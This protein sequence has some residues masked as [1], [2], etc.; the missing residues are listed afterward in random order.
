M[1]KWIGVVSSRGLWKSEH[2]FL[3]FPINMSDRFSGHLISG[4]ITFNWAPFNSQICVLLQNKWHSFLHQNDSS[5]IPIWLQL[6][7]R[8]PLT[9]PHIFLGVPKRILTVMQWQ[10]PRGI[11]PHFPSCRNSTYSHL[12]P[13]SITRCLLWT[14]P[15]SEPQGPPA[16]PQCSPSL[17]V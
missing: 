5:V 12:G 2:V 6:D 17:L 3:L 13:Y 16:C 8:S 7:I 14:L 9:V 4:N 15:S 10:S 1:E 11:C